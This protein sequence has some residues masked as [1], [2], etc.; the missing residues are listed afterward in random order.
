MTFFENENLQNGYEAQIISTSYAVF[1]TQWSVA[2]VLPK[3]QYFHVFRKIH[4]RKSSIFHRL[5]QK[6]R[7]DLQLFSI[8]PL[9]PTHKNI[10]TH[11]KV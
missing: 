1:E 10:T 9:H 3:V 4:D 5:K 8:L 7:K 11:K 2:Q 6:R